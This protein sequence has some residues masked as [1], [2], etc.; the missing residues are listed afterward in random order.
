MYKYHKTQIVSKCVFLVNF[1]KIPLEFYNFPDRIPFMV[2]NICTDID[3]FLSYIK[4]RGRSE[5][6]VVSYSVDLKQ[7]A[8]YLEKEG[9]ENSADIDT[10]AV[11]IFLSNILG[12]GNAK[13]SA[14]RKLSAVRGFIRWLST[15]G[16]IK[17]DPV[18]GLKGPKLPGSLPRALSYEDTDMLITK[19]PQQGKHY[20]RDRLIL[21]LMYAAGLR[22]SE[23]IGLDWD[24]VDFESRT[25]RIMGKG[26][27]E[28][29]APFG[30]ESARLLTDWKLVNGAKENGPVFLSEKGAERLTVRTV[31]RVVL[32]AA[33]NVGLS[34]V[35]PHTLRH[36]FATHMLERGA[37][38]RVVQELLGHDSISTTQR[39]L[40]IT[41]EQIKKSYMES[42]PRAH[43]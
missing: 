26:E 37:P 14:A 32:R 35:S 28:G 13:T 23:L 29:I 21:E 19:G 1:L 43:A 9:I 4:S 34:G 39:Y 31:H 17:N 22:V 3:L 33:A 18:T 27:K 10:D 2:K 12:V 20:N 25:L 42:H 8:D 36:C 11:R 41:T 7:F 38:L 15:R 16:I 40:S 5:N 6:T 24:M 30:R